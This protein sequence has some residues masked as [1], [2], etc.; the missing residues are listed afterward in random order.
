MSRDILVTS[1]LPY[2]NGSIHLGHLVEYIQTDI[3]VRFQRLLGNRCLYL[4]A[5]D[6]HGTP[7]MLKAETE[8][9][10]AEELVA[11]VAAEQ[12]RDFADFQIEFDNF[13][14]THSQENQEL[15]Y[16]IYEA[17][18]EAG[19]IHT[20]PVEQAYDPKKSM[21]LPDRYVRG[22]CPN[23]GTV[24]QYGDACENC[25]ATYSPLELVDAVSVVSGVAPVRRESEHFFFKL[26]DFEAFLRDWVEKRLEPALVRKLDEWFEAGLRDWDIS[27]DAPYF[28]FEIPDAQGKYF[29]VWLDAPVGYLA[30]LKHLAARNPDLNFDHYWRSEEAEVYHFIGKDIAY[31]HTLFWPAVLKGAGMRTPTGVFVHGF[32][33]ING[34]KMSKRRGTFIQ[35][36]DYLEE[37]RPDYLR[38]YYATKLSPGIEDI[39]LSLDD[40]VARTNSDLVGKVINIAS[41]CAG[42]IH[43]LG[44]GSLAPALPEPSLFE[45]AANAGEEIAE[46]Y[47]TREYGR[48][49]RIVMGLADET[50]QYLDREKPWV[51]AK[52]PAQAAQVVSITT[53][54]INQFRLLMVYLKPV[55][56]A[57][58]QAAE[59][60]LNA[61]PLTWKN[62]VEP[63]LGT[64]IEPFQP[65]LQRIDADSIDAILARAAVAPEA[66]TS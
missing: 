4:C 56:P 64:T 16:D 66:S 38:Y 22:T 11:R 25:G 51:L 3:W 20:R 32:L 14:S 53:Q 62:R 54:G 52:D 9:V 7:I 29:Y 60:F 44:D 47:E 34:K 36:R 48:A 33:T 24:D 40:F 18:K 58:A 13:H 42:F 39:D 12:Q 46:C 23:C 50:N 10:S 17:L 15:T 45:T 5:S 21:F 41:R 49:M 31:F 28:G 35:A 19:H 65:L 26:A 59:A 30:S 6:A 1:A 27:R 55:L 63:L 2:A 8:G 61:G 43:R 57:V 37:L